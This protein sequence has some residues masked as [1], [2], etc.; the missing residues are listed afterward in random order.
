MKRVSQILLSLALIAVAIG[1]SRTPDGVLGKEKMAQLIADIHVGESVVEASPGSF[2]SDSAKRAFRQSI[3]AR[4]GLTTEQADKSFRWYGYN[5][6]R[7]IEVYDRVL[8]ILEQRMRDAELQAGSTAPAQTNPENNLALEGDSVN[9][10]SS[11]QFRPFSSM[12]ESNVIPFALTSDVNWER[13]DVYYFR[14]KLIG[15][16][17]PVFFNVAIDYED[18]TKETFSNQMI[19]DGWHDISFGLDTLRQ[20][21]QIY[22]TIYYPV[23]KGETAFIDSLSLTRARWT[24]GKPT[25][26]SEMK[27]FGVKRH[28][29][30]LD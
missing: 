28:S 21:R 12:L 10:W 13:G 16:S 9:V 29:N 23:P 2:R 7:Y 30:R 17:S 15:N 14:S 3:Y 4:H 27:R 18:G 25:P 22:G 24:S 5:M 20:A 26:R 8:E 6:E 1:C 11:V 19:G